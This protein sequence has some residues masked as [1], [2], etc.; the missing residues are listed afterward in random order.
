[1]AN[2]KL[3]QKIAIIGAGAVGSTTAYSLVM[4][5]LAA[6][7]ILIDVNKEKEQGEAIIKAIARTGQILTLHFPVKKD[8]TDELADLIINN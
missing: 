7:V 5:N 2:D 1:M 3:K 4:K 8:D 6:E